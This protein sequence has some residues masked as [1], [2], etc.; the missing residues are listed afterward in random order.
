MHRVFHRGRLLEI[1]TERIKYRSENSAVVLYRKHPFNENIFE[2]IRL[3]GIPQ[4]DR[5]FVILN[6]TTLFSITSK[7]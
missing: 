6:R 2:M 3:L 7:N 4:V 1:S 5:N